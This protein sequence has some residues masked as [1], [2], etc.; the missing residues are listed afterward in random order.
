MPDVTRGV[1]K[2]LN[3]TQNAG[4]A[5]KAGV[6][7][8]KEN[9]MAKAAAAGDKMARK[10]QEAVQSGKFAASL[11]RVSMQ[12]WQQAAVNKGAARL[13]DGARNGQAKYQAFAAQFYPHVDAV[14][15][16]VRAMPSNTLE[17]GIARAA[18]Q[19]RGNAAFKRS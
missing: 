7:S 14:A 19:I 18:A 15:Q 10:V 3:N 12:A 6:Q 9:P 2:W 16:Q 17:D 4:E 11:N 1:A 13:A 5:Y 8:V